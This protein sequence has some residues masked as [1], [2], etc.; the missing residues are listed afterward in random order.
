MNL[1]YWYK[2]QSEPLFSKLA[3]SR[4]ENK[5]HAGKLL[6]VGG[7]KH[8]FNAP[9][10]AYNFAQQAGIGTT[11]VLMP[12]SVQKQMKNMPGVNLEIEYSPSTPSGSFATKALADLLDTS[13]ICDGVLLA[14]NLGRNSETAIMLEKFIAKYS[15]ILCLTKDAVEYFL[16]KP[17]ELAE[18][19]NTCVIL[20]MAQLQKMAISLKF[21]PVFKFSDELLKTVTNLHK[22]SLAHKMIVILKHLDTIFVASKGK[23]STT[24][25]DK[26]LDNWRTETASRAV[27]WWIQNPSQPFEA[28]TNA[29]ATNKY[30]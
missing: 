10:Q 4:P 3:W 6:I 25:L 5:R 18:R 27:V 28:M 19:D 7:N 13:S 15:G 21:E 8:E 16:A 9:A 26:K 30:I 23:V 1:E 24:K 29:V 12:S 17:D 20:T 11:R 22:F 14:G 2:Q